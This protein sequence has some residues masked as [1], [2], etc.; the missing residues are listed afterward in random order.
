MHTNV[1]C[2]DLVLGVSGAKKPL[3]TSMFIQS[4]RQV[5]LGGREAARCSLGDGPFYRPSA[6]FKA[7]TKDPI[8]WPKYRVMASES[9]QHLSNTDEMEK[10]I[11]QWEAPH[12]PYGLL[13]N[14]D[15]GVSRSWQK[16]ESTHG[17][18]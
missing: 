13:F 2:I 16:S 15:A 12:F 8:Y 9:T 17:S 18:E 3:T 11:A 5:N 4:N 7:P 14:E 6:L 10:F 1:S